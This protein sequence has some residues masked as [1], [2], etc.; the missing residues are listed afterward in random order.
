MKQRNKGFTLV[1]LMV[2]I[3]GSAVV[4]SAAYAFLVYAYETVKTAELRADNSANVQ[5]LTAHLHKHLFISDLKQLAVSANSGDQLLAPLFVPYPNKCANLANCAQDSALLYP[6]ID[7]KVAAYVKVACLIDRGGAVNAVLD[8][9]S[10]DFGSWARSGNRIIVN[11]STSSSF[12]PSGEIKIANGSLLSLQDPNFGLSFI[13]QSG[14]SIILANNPAIANN[15]ECTKNLISTGATNL[16]LLR[17][18]PL[19]LPG[20]GGAAVTP[21]IVISAFSK[22]P[23][24]MTGMALRSLGRENNKMVVKPCTWTG[25]GSPLCNGQNVIEVQDIKKVYLSYKF[26]SLFSSEALNRSFFEVGTT[27]V[28]PTM[29]YTNR[30]RTA[31]EMSGAFDSGRF[32]LAKMNFLSMLRIS[33]FLDDT[34]NLGQGKSN[35]KILEIQAF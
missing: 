4:I 14:N 32:S 20:T 10:K 6:H 28:G 7:S 24:R 21:D 8:P 22:F 15:P 2:A 23:L 31:S 17:L 26:D 11:G 12:F 9:A 5:V 25:G 34:K 16:T 33:F 13:V 29:T 30:V 1:E 19:I 35:V 27:N 3:A 18:R